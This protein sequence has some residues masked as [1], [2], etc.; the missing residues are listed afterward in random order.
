MTR[1]LYTNAERIPAYIKK[2]ELMVNTPGQEDAN[3][4]RK[5]IT[6][7]ETHIVYTEVE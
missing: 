7:L 5:V 4:K 6:D 2:K 1:F 3:A